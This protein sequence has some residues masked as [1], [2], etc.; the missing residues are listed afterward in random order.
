MTDPI[1]R[2]AIL[3]TSVALSSLLAVQAISIYLTERAPSHAVALLPY[4]GL[5]WERI[6]F[7]QFKE[8]L[9][10]R[11]GEDPRESAQAAAFSARAFALEAI[12]RDP[13]APRAYAVVV[14][15]SRLPQE[16]EELLALASQLNRHHYALQALVMDQAAANEDYEKVVETLDQMLRVRPHVR[17]RF[18]GQKT[19]DEH[20]SC[21]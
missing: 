20:C 9:V 7:R 16:R 4:N 14:L 17:E 3:L 8:N 19:L 1:R 2:G 18:D 13:L 5:A 6:A 11:T 12:R 21:M 10:T 15:S